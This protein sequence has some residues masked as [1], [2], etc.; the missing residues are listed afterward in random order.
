MIIYYGLLSAIKAIKIVYLT[1][2]LI[3]SYANL[4]KTGVNECN[5]YKLSKFSHFLHFEVIKFNNFL[6]VKIFKSLI[7]N[8]SQILLA[9]LSG[10]KKI[11]SQKIL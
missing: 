5:N 7:Y 6:S 3:F 2:S 9:F 1:L 4:F 8:L 10:N 11:F